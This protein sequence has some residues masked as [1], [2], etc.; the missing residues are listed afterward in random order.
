MS[1]KFYKRS[2]VRNTL[3]FL[4]FLILN[5]VYFSSLYYLTR[6]FEYHE[7][8]TLIMV[9]AI[10]FLSFRLY[11]MYQE[12]EH[13][14]YRKLLVKSFIA[15]GVSALGAGLV[16]LWRQ[17]YGERM[18][19][20]VFVI[21]FII[22]TLTRFF[23]K[24]YISFKYKKANV[25]IIGYENDIKDIIK[26][27]FIKYH[28][29]YNIS[30]ISPENIEE[31]V[32]TNIDEVLVSQNIL[33][34]KK[35]EIV[36]YILENNLS[37]KIIPGNYEI[38]V[39]TAMEGQ[40]YDSFIFY[41]MSSRRLAYKFFKRLIDIVG[42]LALFAI[43]WPFM[44]IA[45]VALKIENIKAP[46]FYTQTRVTINEKIF[47][48]LK[49][50]S[51]IVNAEEISGAVV[52]QKNDARIT[53]VGSI[54]RKFRIDELPQILNVLKGDMSLVGPRPERPEFTSEY[55]KKIQLYSYRHRVKAGLTGLAQISGYY[56]TTIEDKLK[57]DLYYVEKHSILLD[58][59]IILLTIEVILDPSKAEGQG[60]YATLEDI[61]DK[62]RCKVE[63][64]DNLYKI[65]KIGKKIN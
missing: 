53:R 36:S 13:I 1:N 28:L 18:V 22:T 39:A 14:R 31:D 29:T 49:F 63:K 23:A 2:V 9:V 59:K 11:N 55:E 45:I 46:I 27:F 65:V 35:E 12:L 60:D 33:P 37:Y 57:H 38:V 6:G 19:L 58:V 8:I 48:V 44:I 34:K 43:S 10:T 7:I 17:N 5:I 20:R 56:S 50:R 41:K 51:M 30:Y 32:F 24:Y 47:N 4:D 54:L 42:S 15:N 62:F 3:Y 61:L 64:I 52:A 16:F 40:I 25:L 26:K 21:T